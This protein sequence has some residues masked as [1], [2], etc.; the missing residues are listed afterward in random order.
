M[1]FERVRSALSYASFGSRLKDCSRT[2]TTFAYTCAGCCVSRTYC[3][4][5]A[6]TD[7]VMSIVAT[8]SFGVVNLTW[9]TPRS[10][11]ARDCGMFLSIS[12]S[13]G[14]LSGGWLHSGDEKQQACKVG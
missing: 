1:L 6:C 3:L 12:F 7:W 11:T 8:S 10:W 13:G 2:A 5:V 14:L 9:C 4:Q